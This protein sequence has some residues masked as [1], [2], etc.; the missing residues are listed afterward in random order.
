MTNSLSTALSDMP[1][2]SAW[3]SDM[4]GVLVKE[5]RALPGAQDFISALEENGIPFLVL[6]NNSIFTNRDLSARLAN[7]GLKVPEE[8]I[9]TSANATAAFLSQQSPNSTAYVIGEAGLT[10]ALHTAGYVMTDQDPEY[11][12]L[13][14]TR[15]YD[16]YALTTAI[17]LIER[18]AKFIG[19]GCPRWCRG[20]H[21]DLL[22]ALGFDAL[23]GRGELPLPSLPY[24]QRNW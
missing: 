13:G 6:T 17:R 22:G 8:H 21:E 1:P 9:W 23:R 11:V 7:S 20:R 19:Y 18:G 14:E 16:F 10:T 12:V 3:L 5:N 15:F 2:I 4:D 24:L